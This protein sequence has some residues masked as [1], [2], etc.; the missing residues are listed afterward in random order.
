MNTMGGSAPPT[1]NV[2][3]DESESSAQI[4]N[5]ISLNLHLWPA[6]NVAIQNAW[7]TSSPA[8]GEDKRAWLAGAISDL[9]AQNQVRDVEDLEDI[10]EQAMSDEFEVVVDDGSLEEIARKIYSGRA[11]VLQG[12][13]TEVTRLMSIWEERRKKKTIFQAVP[14]PEVDQE[15]DDDEDEEEWNGFQDTRDVDM[16]E[17]PALIDS[18]QIKKKPEPEVDEEGFTKVVGKK[19]K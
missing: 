15:T 11:K 16:D 19:K 17:A 7:G 3:P 4:D 9:F 1:S 14:G 5:L 13:A 2:K 18:A 6:L 10:L 12:D 8:L